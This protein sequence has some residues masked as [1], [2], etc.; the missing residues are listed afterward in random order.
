MPLVTYPRQKYRV[1]SNDIW[2]WREETVK[3]HQFRSQWTGAGTNRDAKVV[4]R[5]L[6]FSGF[7]TGSALWVNIR[8]LFA[9]ARLVCS[10]VRVYLLGFRLVRYVA[11]P[12]LSNVSGGVLF[13]GFEQFLHAL[14]SLRRDLV[15]LQ[16]VV[17]AIG[18]GL[19]G[20]DLSRRYIALISN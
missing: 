11:S 9:A 5:V 17:L 12:L 8:S 14:S 18:L 2:P 13:D 10:L 4:V 1:E 15:V 3:V 6:T 16:P 20:R 7:S 19:L